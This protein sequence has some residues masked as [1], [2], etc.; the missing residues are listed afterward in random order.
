MTCLFIVLFCTA[1]AAA[2][3]TMITATIAMTTDTSGDESSDY[4]RYCYDYND[5]LGGPSM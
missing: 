4:D 3:V 5:F 2:A 1:A